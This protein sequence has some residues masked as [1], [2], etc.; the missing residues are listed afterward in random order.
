MKLIYVSCTHSLKVILYVLLNIF[1]AKIIHGVEF[2]TYGVMTTLTVSDFWISGFQIRDALPVYTQAQLR[3]T[4]Q[5][6]PNGI[7]ACISRG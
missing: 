4:F 1:C 5:T 6:R 7:A 3:F 2:S